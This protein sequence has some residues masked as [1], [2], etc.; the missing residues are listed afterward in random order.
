MEQKRRVLDP[1]KLAPKAKQL[2]ILNEDLRVSGINYHNIHFDREDRLMVVTGRKIIEFIPHL[3]ER[4][5]TV[6]V[7]NAVLKSVLCPPMK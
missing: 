1:R 3:K 4:G 2:E 7:I 6:E 5:L